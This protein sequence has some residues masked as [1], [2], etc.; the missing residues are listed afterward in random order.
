M[1]QVHGFGSWVYGIRDQSRPLI[2]I[3]AARILLKRK[4][5]GDVILA[6]HLWPGI[7]QWTGRWGWR[8]GPVR[9][10]HRGLDGAPLSSYPGHADMVFSGQNDMV[11]DRVLTQGK[12][13]LGTTPRWLAAEASH[14]QAWAMV[15]GGSG[16]LPASWSSPTSSSWPPL[17]S[18]PIQLL[19]SVMNS[20]NMVAAR[21]RKAKIWAMGCAIYLRF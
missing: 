15:S 3:W 20:S 11:V 9:W 14:L 5:I 18:R 12:T 19:Q 1:D 10:R 2:L 16:A 17:A 8:T 6:L 13:W 7:S 4:G 21:V